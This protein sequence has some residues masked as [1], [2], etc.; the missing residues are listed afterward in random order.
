MKSEFLVQLYRLLQTNLMLVWSPRSG[1]SAV[2]L[3]YPRA[4]RKTLSP[5]SITEIL[6]YCHV[7]LNYIPEL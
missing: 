1:E 3:L 4:A 2:L 5:L 6:A 7:F